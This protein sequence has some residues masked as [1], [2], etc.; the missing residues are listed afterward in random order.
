MRSTDATIDQLWKK[1]EG[2]IST[3]YGANYQVVFTRPQS[4]FDVIIYNDQ[5]PMGFITL[6]DKGKGVYSI[7]NDTKT[8]LHPSFINT[9]GHG[10]EV[11]TKYRKRGIGGILI[12]LA[13]G[14]IQKER[15]A[16]KQSKRF[17]IVASD[18][19]KEGLGCYR[20]FGFTVRE[21]MR[22]SAAYFVSP[23][24]TPETNILQAKASF[25]K[26]LK[27]RLGQIK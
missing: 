12:N 19:T 27:V 23:K 14:M 7:V 6:K 17:M 15:Q 13:L 16:N 26:R 22:I 5:D 3:D 24:T 10:I 4:F 18:I 25:F 9:P 8:N 1:R 2:V 20:N 21:G 11:K